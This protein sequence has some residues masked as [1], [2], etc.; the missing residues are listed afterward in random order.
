[1]PSYRY[2]CG[3]RHEFEVWRSIKADTVRE[4]DCDCGMVGKL[5]VQSPAILAAALPNKKG[6]ASVREINEREARW[7]KDLPAYARLRKNGVQP[8]AIDGSAE[9][10]QRAETRT[11]LEMGKVLPKHAAWVGSELSSEMLGKA[12]GECA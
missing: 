11:E 4:V 7:E 8:K 1:V 10:E 12:V 6:M 5:V 9:L 3:K 2:R